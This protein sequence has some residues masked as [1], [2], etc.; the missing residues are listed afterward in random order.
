MLLFQKSKQEDICEER[1]HIKRKNIGTEFTW[2][3]LSKDELFK[4]G[5]D[6][7]SHL[8]ISQGTVSLLKQCQKI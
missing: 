3:S 7:I 8:I 2:G 6:N 5:G 4:G 1:V